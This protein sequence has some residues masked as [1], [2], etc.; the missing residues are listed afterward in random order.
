MNL[1]KTTKKGA[2]A[3]LI[4]LVIFV[5]IA[6]LVPFPRNDRP[7]SLPFQAGYAIILS[8]AG[9]AKWQTRRIQN[10]LPSKVCGFES[11]LRHRNGLQVFLQA[12]IVA[13]FSF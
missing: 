13:I 4:T 2:V 10:P 8:V 12:V 5:L 6:F 7:F 3:L 9:V 1:N 11:R